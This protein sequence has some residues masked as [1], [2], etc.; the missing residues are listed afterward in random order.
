[1]VAL[2]SGPLTQFSSYDEASRW[3]GTRSQ[4][5]S[6]FSPAQGSSPPLIPIGL[7]SPSALQCPSPGPASHIS[8]QALRKPL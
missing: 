4:G 5:F 1:M 3:E 6:F 2:V 8:A 7:T